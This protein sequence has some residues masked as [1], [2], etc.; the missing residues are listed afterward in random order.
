MSYL[1]LSVVIVI[2]AVPEG[3]PLTITMALS[4]SVLRMKNDNILVKTLNSPEMMGGVEEICCRKTGV[5]TMNDMTVTGF[6]TQSRDITN[7]R[8]STFLNCDLFEHV[9]ELIKECIMY[10]CTARIE[11]DSDSHYVPVG[12][13]TEVGLIKFL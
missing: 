9:I 7:K 8:K 6:Y 12:N 4:Y 2:V 3:L 1:T 10:N 11:M 5:L 13:G